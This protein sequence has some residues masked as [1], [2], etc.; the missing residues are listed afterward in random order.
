MRDEG[1]TV[2]LV[3]QNAKAALQ[4]A[5]RGYVLET[6]KVVLQGSSHELLEDVEVFR[7]FLVL[8]ERYDGLTH[9]RIMDLQTGA[10][11][12]RLAGGVQL[13]YGTDA[14]QVSSGVEYRSDDVQQLDL[15]RAALLRRLGGGAGA[16]GAQVLGD[17]ALE[18]G[19]DLHGT[20]AG[21]SE[22]VEDLREPVH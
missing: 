13:G 5:D 11:T 16:P 17:Q 2:L 7:D 4:V 10:E 21:V 19:A 3:E 9:L 14:L 20:A 18:R 1:K 12:D 15:A 8:G 6:G 22:P